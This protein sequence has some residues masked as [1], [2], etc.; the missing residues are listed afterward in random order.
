MSR[1]RVGMQ[2]R[3]RQRAVEQRKGAAVLAQ[4]L[5]EREVERLRLEDLRHQVLPPPLPLLLSNPAWACNPSQACL[6]SASQLQRT[7]L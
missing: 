4:Q 3:D 1:V 5:V 2:D 6:R 7:S